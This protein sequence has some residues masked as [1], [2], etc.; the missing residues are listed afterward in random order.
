ML[1]FISG[2]FGKNLASFRDISLPGRIADPFKLHGG[3]DEMISRGQMP[4][5]MFA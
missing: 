5:N 3:N 2:D 1:G 4:L